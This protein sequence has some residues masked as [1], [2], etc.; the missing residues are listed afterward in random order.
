MDSGVDVLL[1]DK[2][3]PDIHG[4]DLI[5]E[6][7]KRQVDAEVIIITGYASLDT[8]LIAMQRGAF[9]YIVKPPRSI[10]DVQRKVEQALHRQAIGRENRE[11]VAELAARNTQLEEALATVRQTQAELIQAEKLAGLGTLAAGIAHEVASPLFGV[12]GL[13]EAIQV[14]DDV[15]AIHRL[16]SEIVSNSKAIKEIVVQLSGYVRTAER[17]PLAPVSLQRV[18]SDAIRLIVRSKGIDE[19]TVHLDIAPDLMVAARASELQQVL[20]NLVK[21]AVEA[22]SDIAP[23]GVDAQPSVFVRASAETDWLVVTVQDNGPGIP[24]DHLKDIFDPFFTTKAPGQ[25]T[26]LGLNIVYRLVTHYGGTVQVSSRVGEGATFS[27]R[28]PRAHPKDPL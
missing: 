12:M 26:G 21:N 2:N 10:W 3:L 1:T 16:A 23:R 20:V 17:E 19:R 15:P 11:L 6:A 5:E 8:A 24:A 14:E 25:G 4:L 22:S 7:R 9:D 18:A 28:L 13:A 27:V